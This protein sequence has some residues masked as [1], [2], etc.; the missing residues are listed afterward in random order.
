[1][2]EMYSFQAGVEALRGGKLVSGMKVLKV[3]GATYR[4]TTLSYGSR[5]A[6]EQRQLQEVI[7][8]AG[9]LLDKS[10][11]MRQ[12]VEHSW[13]LSKGHGC[14]GQIDLPEEVWIG[15]KWA[16]LPPTGECE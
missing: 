4:V 9:C 16:W 6:A 3:Y 15:V 11:L 1:M 8:D 10:A 12:T 7:H 2:G 5:E 14:S 13:Y